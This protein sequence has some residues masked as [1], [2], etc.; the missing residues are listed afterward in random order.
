MLVV[1]LVEVVLGQGWPAA[2]EGLAVLLVEDDV[3]ELAGDGE[4][5][6]DDGC[7]FTWCLVKWC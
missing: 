6:M 3:V 4:H 1:V 2:C 5:W 7:H